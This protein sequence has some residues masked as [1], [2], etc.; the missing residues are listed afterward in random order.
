MSFSVNTNTGAAVALQY[1]TATQGQL[2]QTQS[3][4][5]QRPEGR[6]CP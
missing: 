3:A 1:L 5:Q 4:H 6:Q 2:D